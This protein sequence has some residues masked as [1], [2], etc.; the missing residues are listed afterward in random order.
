[1]PTPIHSANIASMASPLIACQ[2]E[3]RGRNGGEHGAGHHEP[4]RQHSPGP[5]ALRL[6]ERA[7]AR[8]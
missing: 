5:G 8:A 6:L 1:M 3:H 4:L 7:V 2:C